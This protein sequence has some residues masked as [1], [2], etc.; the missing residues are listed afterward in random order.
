MNAKLMPNSINVLLVEDSKGDAIL[1]EKALS[2]TAMITCSIIKTVTI[3]AALHILAESEFDVVLLDLSLPD[4]TGT[5]GVQ[6]VHNFAPKLP[7]IVITGYADEELALATIQHGAQDYMLKEQMNVQNIK[8]SI[9]FAIQRKRSELAL[10]NQANMDMLT[11]L[12]NRSLFEIRLDNSLQR[13]KRSGDMLG[14]LFIDLNRFK[15]VN[16]NYGHNLGDRVLQEAARRMK[17]SV[18]PY[19]GLSRFGGDEFVMLIDDI[20]GPADCAKIAQKI[21]AQITKPFMISGHKFEIGVSVGIVTSHSE[22]NFTGEDLIRYADEAM[23]HAKRTGKS[24][25]RFYEHATG[26]KEQA[27]VGA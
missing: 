1:I 3:N 5:E 23:Y 10:V 14:I 25:Y 26:Q 7:I 13:C 15:L 16:D 11:G 8:Q 4:A 19:D 24:E 27:M 12:A 2:Q 9:Q 17:V 22:D 6:A 20:K 21:I 18:R